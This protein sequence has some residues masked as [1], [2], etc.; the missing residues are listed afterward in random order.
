M[1]NTRLSTNI[2]NNLNKEAKSNEIFLATQISSKITK[3][4]ENLNLL[5][6]KLD[7]DEEIL[8]DLIKKEKFKLTSESSREN[9]EKIYRLLIKYVKSKLIMCFNMQKKEST[10]NYLKS[11]KILVSK[12]YNT[13]NKLVIFIPDRQTDCCIFSK[14]S[15]IYGSLKK[16]SIINYVE[17]AMNSNY[18]V[19]LMNP[20]K[21]EKK[22]KTTTFKQYDHYDYCEAVYEEFVLGRENIKNIVFIVNKM[23]SFTM[24]KLINKFKED[25]RLKVKKVILI[26]S[27][28]NSMFEVLSPE[29]RID[30]ETKCTNYITSSSPEGTLLYS[31]TE[32]N[33]GCENRSSGSLNESLSYHMIKEDI[34]KIL[35]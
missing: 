3:I 28:H 9:L 10:S 6:Y 8:V 30:F 16:G 26:N 27:S 32:S 34:G 25:F 4:L 15:L 21:H 11:S 2:P 12:D 14:V 29:M 33:E 23:G 20:Y 19:L 35:N 22:D 17:Q 31:S 1:L 18:S 13:K 5:N 24:I 7:G